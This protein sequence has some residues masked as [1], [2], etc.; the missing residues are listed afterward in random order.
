MPRLRSLLACATISLLCLSVPSGAI[1]GGEKSAAQELIEAY[2]PRLMLRERDE[3][4]D[5]DGEQYEATTVNTVLGN[6]AVELTEAD[7]DGDET[8]LKRAPTATDLAGRGEPHHL[9]LPGDPLGDTCDYARDFAKLKRE[10]KAP[11]VTYAHIAREAGRP[12][13]AIQYWF[14]WYFNQFNDLHEG[15]LGGDAG[16]FRIIGPPARA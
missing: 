6:P 1:A 4:C 7:D 13:L 16:R 8:L 3:I 14:F 5:T 15:R 2:T 12:G 11:A 9:N 10:G